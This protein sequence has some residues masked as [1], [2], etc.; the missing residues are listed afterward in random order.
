MSSRIYTN[1]NFNGK[2]SIEGISSIEQKKDLDNN[3]ADEEEDP[4]VKPKEKVSDPNDQS[5]DS[6]EDPTDVIIFDSELQ[7]L[8]KI[9]KVEIVFLLDTTKSM[10]PYMA[11]IKRFI[12]KL[13]FDAKKTISHYETAELDALSLGLIG[14]KDHDQ[15]NVRGSYVSKVLCDL[16]CDHDKF[17]KALFSIVPSGGDD[18]C[19]AVVDG[20]NEIVQNIKWSDDSIKFVY[21]I[22]DAPAHGK[23]YTEG[24]MEKKT[25]NSIIDNYEAGCP[26]GM[27][28]KSILKAMRGKYIEY[29]IIGIDN[30]V[31][32]M[33]QEFSKFVKIDVMQPTIEKTKGVSE[34]QRDSGRD[35]IPEEC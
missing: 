4:I 8:P 5:Y 9:Y 6:E 11:G 32:K 14:Y 35:E 23:I 17:R 27:E 30:C 13:V 16:T 29:T 34:A 22:C 26:C 10:N 7:F 15:A 28:P 21:H 20:L 3:Y 18:D 12:R 33:I 31:D 1:N 2:E 25:K 19:E 24:K